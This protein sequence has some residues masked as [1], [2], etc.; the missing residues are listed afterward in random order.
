MKETTFSV[1]KYEVEGRS[2]RFEVGNESFQKSSDLSN[3][4]SKFL[5]YI[6]RFL[7]WHPDF[8]YLIDSDHKFQYVSPSL[9]N[10]WQ[11][12]I[13]EV[14]GKTFEELGYPSYLCALHKKQ[15]DLAFSKKTIRGENDYIDQ[16]GKWG[17]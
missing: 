13:N 9:L 8:I 6:Y 12:D 16:N 11:K 10:L 14:V 7:K 5:E 4:S 2:Y 15:L 1:F 3:L 17:Y